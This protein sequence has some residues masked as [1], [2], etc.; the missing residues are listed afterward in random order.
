MHLVYIDDSKDNRFACFAAL[1]I[2]ADDWRACLDSLIA[3]RRS[4]QRSDCVYLR[5]EIHATD[6]LMGKG[7]IGRHR[8]SVPDRVRL[9]TH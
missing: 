3:A 8:I 2:P 9:Y 1:L 7:R 5:T 6:W 4:M